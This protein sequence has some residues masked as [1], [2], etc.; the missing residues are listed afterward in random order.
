MSIAQQFLR[1]FSLHYGFCSDS[2]EFL[3]LAGPIS[4]CLS[5]LLAHTAT[6]YGA[7]AAD[8]CFVETW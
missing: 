4:F 5:S 2:A 3:F 1:T 8:L 7:R 6:G